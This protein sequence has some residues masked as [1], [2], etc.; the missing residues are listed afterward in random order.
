FGN[1]PG[2][3]SQ[4]GAFFL[5]CPVSQG[6]GNLEFRQDTGTYRIPKAMGV[7]LGQGLCFKGPEH[8]GAQ[9]A[10]PSVVQTE[11]KP[12]LVVQIDQGEYGDLLGY[13][14][15]EG[16]VLEG[17]QHQLL[18]GDPTFG[19]DADAQALP[20]SVLCP[21]VDPGPAP[22]VLPIDQ[23][24]DLLVKEPKNGNFHQLLLAHE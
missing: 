24:A 22:V 20:Q 5:P 18:V 3:P 12:F 14:H 2:A 19:K 9:R 10:G 1:R 23:D 8:P 7:P 13:G 6:P 16:P 21:A 17:I 11:G 15:L 4:D